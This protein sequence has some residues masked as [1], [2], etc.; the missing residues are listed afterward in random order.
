MK[1]KLLNGWLVCL[2][3]AL[4]TGF[5]ACSDDEGGIDGNANELILGKWELTYSKGYEIWDGERDSWDEPEGGEYI[6][7]NADGTATRSDDSGW[8]NSG[9]KWS[10]SGNK[11]TLTDDGESFTATIT[12]LN[13]DKLVIVYDEEYTDEDG[14]YKYHEEQTFAKVSD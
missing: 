5:T 10:I 8:S 13:A 7:F 9:V 12:T 3:M 1:K 6:E 14:D 4:C 2:C 11:L